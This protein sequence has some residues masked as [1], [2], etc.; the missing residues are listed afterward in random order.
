MVPTPQGDLFHDRVVPGWEHGLYASFGIGAYGLHTHVSCPKVK[1]G[2]NGDEVVNF[3]SGNHSG[4]N[5]GFGWRFNPYVALESTVMLMNGG[6][7]TTHAG[8]PTARLARLTDSAAQEPSW[9]VQPLRL[10]LDL[11]VMTGLSVYGTAGVG[12]KVISADIGELDAKTPIEGCP[13][14]DK[15]FQCPGYYLF[16]PLTG[17]TSSPPNR[18]YFP[19]SAGVEWWIFQSP[20]WALN[21]NYQPPQG[22][23]PKF[24]KVSVSIVG[25]LL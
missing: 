23:G 17:V 2:C 5:V 3:T 24:Y 12:I 13:K 22:P 10:R 8:A 1:D 21:I 7:N 6:V 9:D 15:N 25:G 16:T 14:L 4:F 20:D 19:L 18:G 11:P